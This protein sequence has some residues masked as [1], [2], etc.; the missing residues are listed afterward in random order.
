[1]KKQWKLKEAIDIEASD[2]LASE[3]K[4]SKL[5]TSL[6]ILRN[7]VT[8]EDSRNFFRPSLDNL[9]D[10]FLMKDMDK[11]VE[12][13]NIAVKN[14]ENI[15][16]YGDYD[17]D[18]TTSVSL[19]YNYL[20]E[21]HKN[22]GY[23][24]PDRNDEGYGI[25]FKGIDY[26]IKNKYNLIIA[27]DC[28]IKAVDKIEYANKNNIDFIICD[29]HTPGEAIPNAVA[30]L[31]PKRTDCPYPYK[32]LSG[33]GVGFKLLHGYA[34]N[35]NLDLKK[36]YTFLDLVVVSI[37]SDIVPIT[38]ENRILA[39]FGL[40]ILNTNPQTGLKTIIELSN[41]SN[42]QIVISEIVFKIG[43]RINAA[44]RMESGS[45]AVDLL[46]TKE[47]RKSLLIGNQINEINDE[48]KTLDHNITDEAIEQVINYDKEQK[49]NTTVVYSEDW[50]KGVIGIVAS[51]LI[52]S[53]FRPTVVLAK[54]NGLISGSARSVPGFNLYN[55]IDYCSEYLENYGGHMYAAG[56]TLKPENLQNFRNSFEEYVSKNITDE[57]KI[58]TL[59]ADLEIEVKHIN[60]KFYKILKQFAP[61]G[62]E[63]MK[64]VFIS[65]HV[66]DNGQGKTVGKNKEHLK[67]K[68]IQHIGDNLTI[69]AIGFGFGKQYDQTSKFQAFN[70]CYTIEENQFMGSTKLQLLIRDI[71]PAEDQSKFSR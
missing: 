60:K 2:K 55:A 52:E 49:L 45:T 65:K 32:D 53:F 36:L 37:G 11:A 54:S 63:N 19:I 4:I 3:L 56:L 68:I 10:P 27:L 70:I 62:P 22:I 25:S 42:K 14:K 17:V 67:L 24:I 57:Q 8:Y 12:R 21:F 69:D 51:R 28:G 16:I 64:P 41:L 5:L 34:L 58:P 30:V 15:L 40:K 13:L 50:H 43:P 26:A 59:N 29:H 35:N 18:G 47:S 48:R 7:I 1:M 6:L 31:D 61:F 39:F 33:C 44:G 20:I 66:F 23:Y 46:I 38:G 9:H 71:Y